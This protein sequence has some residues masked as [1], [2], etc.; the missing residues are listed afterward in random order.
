VEMSEFLN[1]TELHTLTGYART[2][3]QSTWLKE[4]GIVHKLDG[5]RLIVMH[6]HVQAWME[7]RHIASGVFNR[8][9]IK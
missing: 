1:Q 5:S 6:R 4:R 2:G 9:L 7:G 8:S 3:A